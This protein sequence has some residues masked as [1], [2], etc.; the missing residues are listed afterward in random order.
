MVMACKEVLV[1]FSIQRIQS[2]R[3][4]SLTFEAVGEMICNDRNINYSQIHFKINFWSIVKCINV[5]PS[6]FSY[7][8][9]TGSQKEWSTAH[10]VNTCQNQDIGLCLS[11]GE[12]L[13]CTWNSPFV[14]KQNKY[15]AILTNILLVA[16]NVNQFNPV[17][18]TLL[19]WNLF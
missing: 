15:I 2:V 5:L 11:N 12:L 6:H 16:L 8:R 9:R 10:S 17:H 1:L 4:P 18:I 7:T 3:T 14:M 19:F 13:S